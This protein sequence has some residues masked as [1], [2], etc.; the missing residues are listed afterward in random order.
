MLATPKALRICNRYANELLLY[1]TSEEK[2]DITVFHLL[3]NLVCAFSSLAR[4]L[5]VR[6]PSHL[7]YHA[8]QKRVEDMG[9]VRDRSHTRETVPSSSLSSLTVPCARIGP[10]RGGEQRLRVQALAAFIRE[11]CHD[12]KRAT[13]M[14]AQITDEFLQAFVSKI[15]TRFFPRALTF[16]AHKYHTSSTYYVLLLLKKRRYD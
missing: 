9:R 2:G 3:Y 1:A 11:S 6:P 10:A 5:I 16:L 12:R 4:K 8:T 7:F 13:R 15:H 14:L